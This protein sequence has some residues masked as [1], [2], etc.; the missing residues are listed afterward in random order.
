MA[1]FS[2]W[3]R[4]PAI[5]KDGDKGAAA[6]SSGFPLHCHKPCRLW[7]NLVGAADP[8][9]PPCRRDTVRI[10]FRPWLV[11]E[12]PGH[13]KKIMG[14]VLM[15]SFFIQILLLSMNAVLPGGDRQGAGAPGPDDAGRAD[16][17]HR[18]AGVFDVL[19][20]G[21]RSYVMAHTT[22][23]IDVTLGARL[24]D[25]LLGLPMGISRAARRARAWRGCASWRISATFD[26]LGA[27][28][29]TRFVLH[30]RVSGGHVVLQP[31]S[32]DD[33]DGLAAALCRDFRHREPDPPKSSGGTVPARPTRALS[34]PSP[35]WR[36]S[37]RW[38]SS[39][40]CSGAGRNSRGLCDGGLPRPCGRSLGQ[41]VDHA[42]QQAHHG[43]SAVFRAKAVLAGDI[44]IGMLIAFNMLA[45]QVSQ[46]VLRLAQLWQ[47]FQ[48]A[49]ISVSRLG[50]ILN[51]PREAKQ[52]PVSRPR[53]RSRQNHAGE[54]IVSLQP[55]RAENSR[56]SEHGDPARRMWGSWARAVAARARSPN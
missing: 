13:Y 44:T 34:R 11:R 56:R 1:S 39:R 9:D 27:D 45:G 28:A 10:P 14:E 37:R 52:A 54:C 16:H 32:D 31:A 24:F 50:D 40:S 7:K 41:P 36:R 43:V 22:N 42:G 29:H 19:L 4:W 12:I 5:Q 6:G 30:H 26:V 2:S 25:H 3:P 47:D 49:R 46:P 53:R 21:L 38:R 15:A 51:T 33:R 8:R 20:N 23:R 35:V 17:R 18:H 55:R 48:Q